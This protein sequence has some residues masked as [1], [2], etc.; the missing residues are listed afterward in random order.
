MA[1]LESLKRW[2]SWAKKVGVIREGLLIILRIAPGLASATMPHIRPQLRLDPS[3]D[4][5]WGQRMYD[6]GM[7]A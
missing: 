7:K 5:C 3:R 4:L 6:V 1:C 2:S